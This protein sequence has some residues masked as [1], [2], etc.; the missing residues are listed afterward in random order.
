MAGPAANPTAAVASPA[1]RQAAEDACVTMQAA[2]AALK[3]SRDASCPAP[4]RAQLQAAAGQLKVE[5][6]KVGL[7]FNQASLPGD[8]EA[9][10][11]LQDF[12]GAAATLC[13][14]YTGLA[15]AGGPTLRASLG[16]T[17]TGVVEACAAL[18]RGAVGGAARD[19][20][21]MMLSGFAL[22]MLEAAG[23]APLD[24]RAA[25]GRAI[26]QARW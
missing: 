15:A 20:Q 5:V 12:Q 22:E 7:L 4:S 3:D 23:R 11:L 9:A 6:S 19:A 18:V 8:A 16:A 24:D 10:A 14:A 21:L 2:L 13:M 17:A 1:T 25:I 26:T